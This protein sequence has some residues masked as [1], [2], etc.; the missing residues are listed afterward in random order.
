MDTDVRASRPAPVTVVVLAGGEPV[1]PALAA[2]VPPAVTVIAADSGLAAARRLGLE[3]DLLVGDLDSVDADDLAAAVAAGVAVE[4]HP[5]AKDATDLELALDAAVARGADEVVVLGGAGG[6]LDHLLGGLLLLADERYRH[7]A[8]VA[9]VGPA[10]VTVVRGHARLRGAPGEL[11]SLLPVHGP[12]RSVTTVGLR[13]PL[14]DEDLV[15]GATRGVSNELLTAD[16]EV[17][18]RAGVLLAVQPG[19]PDDPP[20]S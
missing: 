2:H 6:R 18:L 11:V 15:P 8:V 9:H 5:T 3:V 14:V 16:A 17:R 20:T 4:R 7:L 12:A 1:A 19:Q 13:Y 10:T